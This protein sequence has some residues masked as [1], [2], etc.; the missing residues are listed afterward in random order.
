MDKRL[1]N[2]SAALDRNV[3]PDNYP[4]FSRNQMQDKYDR[5]YDYASDLYDIEKSI[6]DSGIWTPMRVRVTPSYA[7]N[8]G[9]SVKDDFKTLIFKDHNQYLELGELY[10]FSGYY[11]LTIDTGIT[12]STSASCQVQRC[13]DFLRFYDDDGI[14]HEIP[15]VLQRMVPY[16]LNSDQYIML[17]DSQIRALVQYSNTSRL[18]KWADVNSADNKCSRF[19]L[20]QYA[21]RTVAIDRHSYTRNNVG[22]I[23]IRLQA[24]QIKVTDDLINNI[25]DA[26]SHTIAV[27]ILNGNSTVQVGQSLQLNTTVTRNG[28]NVDS[29]TIAYTSATPTVASVSTTGLVT[30]VSSSGNTTISAVYSGVSDSVLISATPAVVNNYTIDFTASNNNLS[31]IRLNEQVT[32]IATPKNN[33]STYTSPCTF[34]VVADD[35]V[36]STSLATLVSQTTSQVVIKCANVNTNVGGYFKVKV[37]DA[38]MTTYIRLLVK[39]IF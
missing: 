25:A 28:I 3:T 38:D 39:S 9:S 12:K 35:G 27:H 7:I 32:F 21:Y 37:V 31:S 36:S 19:I 20:Q 23:D 4:E 16:D 13:A 18:I 24:D 10:R 26:Y 15:C 29:P 34:S 14:Y 11:W 33:G 2:I 6:D 1:R 5:D 17:P 30:G 22:Y 8:R